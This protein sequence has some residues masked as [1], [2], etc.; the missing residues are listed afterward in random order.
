VIL[1]LVRKIFLVTV[2]VLFVV[3]IFGVIA[4][5]VM[6]YNTRLALPPEHQSAEA[7]E[8]IY[9]GAACLGC[10]I[11]QIAIAFYGSIAVAATLLSWV[12]YE[13]VL[14]SS[15]WLTRSQL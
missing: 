8:K 4:M 9:D 15:Q 7:I 13:V 12:L 1:N 6:E 5:G 2:L 10:G 11:V 14:L 3:T